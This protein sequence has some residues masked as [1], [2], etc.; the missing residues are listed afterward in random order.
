[1]NAFDPEYIA[2]YHPDF[3]KDFRTH[4]ANKK[5]AATLSKYVTKKRQTKPS[6][7]TLFGMSEKIKVVTA[8]KH[9]HR[10]KG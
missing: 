10:A 8:P 2:T 3:L 5:A 6:H 4:E 1:M 7:G 9:L